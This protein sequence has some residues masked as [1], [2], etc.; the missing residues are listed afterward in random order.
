[1]DEILIR[2]NCVTSAIISACAAWAVLSPQVRD[3]VVVKLGLIGMSMGHGMVA[4]HLMDGLQAAELLH[5]NRARFV[6]NMGVL[7]ILG[8]YWWRY[9]AGERLRDVLPNFTSLHGRNR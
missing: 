2:A 8:G 9:Q 1:M 7:L 5:L 4:I 6:G 3:G